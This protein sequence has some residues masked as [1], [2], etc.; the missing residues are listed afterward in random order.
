M[1]CYA[2]HVLLWF[3][4]RRER[5]PRPAAPRRWRP[6]N[7]DVCTQGFSR[8]LEEFFIIYFRDPVSFVDCPN[9]GRFR[10]TNSK[11]EINLH[12]KRFLLSQDKFFLSASPLINRAIRVSDDKASVNMAIRSEIK[13]QFPFYCPFAALRMCSAN[14]CNFTARMIFRYYFTCFFFLVVVTQTK[15]ISRETPTSI[16][17]TI[18][19]IC[20]IYIFIGHTLLFSTPHSLFK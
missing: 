13:I 10:A 12:A 14:L 3:F 7:D 20:R 9:T 11:T 5:V 6:R 1:T 17:T 8:R 15:P 16:T 2:V 18:E 4:V 19:V